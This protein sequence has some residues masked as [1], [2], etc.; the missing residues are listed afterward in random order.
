[1]LLTGLVGIAFNYKPVAAED[2][3]Y[4]WLT[5]VT[6]P[7]GLYTWSSPPAGNHTAGTWVN[8]TAPAIIDLGSGSRAVFLSWSGGDGSAGPYSTWAHMTA[9]KTVTANYK[10]QYKLTVESMYATVYIHN[11]S[12]YQTNESWIDANTIALAGVAALSSSPPGLYVDSPW[13]NQWAYLVNWTGDASGKHLSTTLP[14]QGYYSDPINMTGPKTAV[15]LWAY[16]FKL[17]VLSGS[18]PPLPDPP[19]SSAGWYYESTLVNLTAPDPHPT[20]INPNAR[21]VFDYWELD[22]VKQTPPNVN[23]TVHMDTNHTA[24]LF[25]RRQSKVTLAD[26]IGN[27]SGIAD[28]GK[29]YWTY[30]NYTFTAPQYIYLS[31]GIRYDF[32]YWELVGSGNIGTSNPIT[33]NITTTFDGATLKARYQTQYYLGVFSS[34]SAVPGFLYPDSDTTGWYDAGA[35]INLKAKPIVD[36]DS[37]TRYAF[38]QWKNHLGGTNPNNNITFTMSQ[39]WN[40][41]AEY[42]LEYLLKW[43]Y[44]PTSI[45]LGPGWPG[46]VWKKNGTYVTYS[47]PLTDVSGVFVF[48]YWVIDSVTYPQGQ[49]SV[50]LGMITGPVYGTA[51]YA[52]KTK[53][54]MTPDTHTE[55]AHAW[56][57]K[58]NVTINAA[59]FDANRLVSGQP[60]DIYGFEI[61]IKWDSQYLEVQDVYLHLDDFF[62]PNDWRIAY[63]NLDNSAGTYMLAASVLGN[64]TG[65]EGTKAIF[66]LTFHVIYDP[67]YP[68]TAWTWIEFDPSHRKLVNHLDNS[69]TPELHWKDCKYTINTVKPTLEVRDA[70]D[71]D[72]YIQVDSNNPQTFF[73]VEVWLLDGVKVHDFYVQVTY[74]KTQIEAIEV[75]IADYLKPPF[76]KYEWSI[77]KGIG[78]V[79]V[80]VAQ[81]SSVPLQNCSGL[82]FTITFKVVQAIYYKIPGPHYLTSDIAIG[83]GELSVMCPA[84]FI[85]K[86]SDTNVDTIKA[87]Y[88]Y[89]P[90][91]G[92]LDMDG[93]VTVL[94]LQLITD[95]YLS[96]PAKYDI[97]GDTVTDIFDYVFVALRFGTCI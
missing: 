37:V 56:C 55:T 30:E 31:G 83:Y 39:P 97:T 79:Y 68:S 62:A 76:I 47:A 85:Q 36:I 52:N 25:Y 40:V 71:G 54:F 6:S 81:D 84:P 12:W 9:N 19:A 51:Y 8:V 77:N 44:S 93:C 33:L 23:L 13:N 22:G 95:N 58:F 21:W 64:Y 35:T 73:D 82:L 10:M 70:A 74:D 16:M 32:R 60:M 48:Y 50:N 65:F 66:T 94:D 45:D 5:I 1:M 67:C 26:N 72:N 86:T 63:E 80:R 2:P 42:D 43:D 91:P 59:N 38:N 15:A 46:Q 20:W 90:L 41:T 89:N 4:Y 34:G 14:Y 27:Q 18:P 87:T 17:Y 61:G 11:G 69:I 88:V 57:N 53:M 29:W 75:V 78:T 24:T 49:S 7:S 92:D 28:T 3:T 96:S